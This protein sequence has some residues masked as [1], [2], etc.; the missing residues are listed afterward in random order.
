[1]FTQSS[2]VLRA[3]LVSSGSK[4]PPF[5]SSQCWSFPEMNQNSR[6]S[7]VDPAT[8]NS[9][10]EPPHLARMDLRIVKR[11]ARTSSGVKACAASARPSMCDIH[12]ASSF[13]TL[14]QESI[15]RGPLSSLTD[16]SSHSLILLSTMSHLDNGPCS[17]TTSGCAASRAASE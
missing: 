15:V 10:A 14:G 6:I 1:M 8:C 16:K 5:T 7:A 4:K 3:S 9:T 17:L 11:I 2:S 12:G 13:Q